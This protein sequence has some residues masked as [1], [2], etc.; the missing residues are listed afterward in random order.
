MAHTFNGSYTNEHLSEVAFPLGGLGAGMFCVEGTGALSTWSLRHHLQHRYEP[1]VFSA[2]HVKGRAPV[3]RVLEGPV[4]RRKYFNGNGH[5]GTHYGL[6]RIGQATFE[7]RFPF[8]TVKLSDDRVP[9]HTTLKAWSP[10]V[11]GDA[12]ASSLPVAS[13]EYTFHNPS[14]SAVE[15]IYSFHARNLVAVPDVPGQSVREAEG[16]FTLWQPGCEQSLEARGAFTAFVPQ[17]DVHV[18]HAWFRGGWFDALTMAWKAVAEGAAIDNP[19]AADPGE[20]ALGASL[21]VPFSVATG[22][23]HTVRL[24]LCWH[25]PATKLS[26]RWPPGGTAQ[27]PEQDEP[28]E[29]HVPWY[30]GQFGDVDAVAA[31]WRSQYEVLRKRSAHFTNALFDTTLS[32]ELMEAVSANL[33]I[34]KSPTV[35]RQADGRLWCWEGCRDEEGCCAGSCTHVWNYAQAVAHLFPQLER[36]LRQTD[37]AEALDSSGHQS[38]R[39]TLPI[40]D[41]AH[42]FHAAA[43]GQLGRVI[44]VYREW[45]IAGDDAWMKSLWEPVHRSLDYCIGT[46]DPDECGML[47]EPHHN[48]SDIEYWGPDGMCTSYYLGALAA[49]VAMGLHIGQDVSR[50]ETILARGRAAMES[51]LWNGEYFIQKVRWK[52]LKAD[53]ATMTHNVQNQTYSSEAVALCQQ[54]GPKY[55]YGCGCLSDGVLGVWIAEMAGL[56]CFL[57]RDKV[58]GHLRAVFEHN[59]KTDLS[60]HPNPQRPGYALGD[61]GGLLLCTWPRGGA[62]SLPFVYSNEV[63]TGIEYQAAGHMVIEGMVDEGL[64]IV[65]TCRQRFDG[66]TRNPFNEYEC[67][68]FYAR[69]LASWGLLR[70]ASGARYDAVD[71][72]LHL[73]PR[74]SG[75]FRAFLA[76]A[77]GYGTVGVRNGEP[78]CEVVEGDI[79]FE[80]IDYVPAS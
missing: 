67:G 33:S 4:P 28:A 24:L 62:P 47:V 75:D 40:A 77:T 8:A 12:D 70:A 2:L 68:H 30:A 54:E 20:P 32:D 11:P 73:K 3:A 46:W 79:P 35:L 15:A 41:G 69:A 52:D 10:F 58:R 16:G 66:T 21:Y 26:W 45:R 7:A 74:V 27:C 65:R 64:A 76:T 72:V 13:L 61:E 80:R 23:E 6:P 78:L 1:A 63:W 48:T 39:I 9:L 19:P 51:E 43:D 50:Y 22:K 71:K 55:Q 37:H 5:M 56:E 34:L 17:G 42:H 38:F 31:H 18:D 44:Q 36:R 25:V 49:L 57:D 29:T 60:T 53:P 14:D 59:F